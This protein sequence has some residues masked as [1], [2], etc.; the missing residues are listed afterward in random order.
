MQLGELNYDGH[1]HEAAVERLLE[2]NEQIQ[3]LAEDAE[4]FSSKE[5]AKRIIPK[6][7]KPSARLKWIEMD[8]KALHDS[9]EMIDLA[10]QINDML[11]A[12]YEIER[13]QKQHRNRRSERLW[14]MMW[15]AHRWNARR[16]GRWD[17]KLWPYYSRRRH[18]AKT[19][20]NQG[21]SARPKAPP[22]RRRHGAT[23]AF[24]FAEYREAPIPMPAPMATNTA[25]YSDIVM[26]RYRLRSALR[27]CRGR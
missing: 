9:E 21:V 3:Y 24:L 23:E 14:M 11:E 8:G 19:P 4:I 20:E 5:M 27:D 7:L 16:D 26:H 18:S 1:D 25:T 6:N 2:I 13:E 10:R 22:R 12:K 15:Q 17:H